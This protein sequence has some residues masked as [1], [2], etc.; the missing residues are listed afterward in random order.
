M[1]LLAKKQ[2][3]ILGQLLSMKAKFKLLH[4]RKQNKVKQKLGNWLYG[5]TIEMKKQLLILK[6]YSKTH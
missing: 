2:S 3:R 1:F 6:N 5:E 4:Q